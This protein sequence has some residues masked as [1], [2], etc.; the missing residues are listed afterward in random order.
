L[1]PNQASVL[2]QTTV[3]LGWAQAMRYDVSLPATSVVG[4]D[5][6]RAVTVLVLI[7][8]RAYDFSL[9]ARSQDQD[10]VLGSGRIAGGTATADQPLA[11]EEVI[12]DS[13]A[14]RTAGTIAPILRPSLLPTGLTGVRVLDA[15]PGSF[16]VA[17]RGPAR[18]MTLGVGAFNPPLVDARGSQQSI[19]VR[20]Q[21]A[22]LQIESAAEPSRRLWLWW[23]EPGLWELPPREA[24]ASIF[25]LISAEGIEPRVIQD[26]VDAIGPPPAAPPA[27]AI[28]TP[29]PTAGAGADTV[30]VALIASGDGTLGCGDGVVL[31]DRRIAPS[32]APLTTA[33][34]ELLSIKD[35]SYWQSGLINALYLSELEIEGVT[36]VQGKATIRLKG[37]LALSGVCDVPRVAAQLEATARQ[38]AS[39]QDVAIFLNGTP[40]SEAWSLR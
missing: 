6:G 22:T 7:G 36:V 4:G 17:Y 38:F 12:W 26:L 39:V 33:I 35:R 16:Q 8:P 13:V 1:L 30:K 14:G 5:P 40:L 20:G 34:R 3:D 37:H 31:V 21:V 2:D 32:R 15:A 9:S 28:S 29:T 23:Q 10:H 19:A 27:K 18:S 25:Y 11:R 24:A